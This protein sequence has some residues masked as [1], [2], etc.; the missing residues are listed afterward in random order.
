V[1]DALVRASDTAE[2]MAVRGY[3]NG[4]SLCPTFMHKRSDLVMGIAA[5]GVVFFAFVPVSEFLILYG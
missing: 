3:D 4:G 1:S 5:I 2:L